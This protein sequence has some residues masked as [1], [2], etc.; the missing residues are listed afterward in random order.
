MSTSDNNTTQWTDRIITEIQRVFYGTLGTR[1]KDL[2]DFELKEDV[3][4]I[5]SRPYSVPKLH[6]G[7]FK[8]EVDILVLLGVL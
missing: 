3:K 2:V 8:K 1:I 4:P 6:E 5:C 7:I